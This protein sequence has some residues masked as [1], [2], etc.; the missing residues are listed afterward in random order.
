MTTRREV[1]A[2]RSNA[3]RS[4]GPRTG[5]GKAL[6]RQNA[7]R[8]GLTSGSRTDETLGRVARLAELLA[9]GS[10]DGAVLA[11]AAIM[12]DTAVELARAR[13]AQ[14]ML[15]ERCDEITAP[16]APATLAEGTG[17]REPA[18]LREDDA[19]APSELWPALTRLARYGRRAMVRR[20]RALQAYT[21]GCAEG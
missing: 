1:D 4:T 18:D 12:A 3:R 19:I 9:G 14:V 8:H 21:R 13:A 17:S 11:C 5:V 20:R 10:T 2:N 15:I 7:R 16:G 6:A